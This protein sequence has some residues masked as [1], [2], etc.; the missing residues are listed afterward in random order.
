MIPEKILSL[1]VCPACKG[2]LDAG[3]GFSCRGCRATYEVVGDVPHLLDEKRK[4]G[5]QDLSRTFEFKSSLRNSRIFKALKYIFGAD[6]VPRDPLRQFNDLFLNK[7]GTGGLVLNMGSGST[8]LAEGVVNMDIE[9]LPNVDIVADGSRL[10]FPP[11]VFDAVI[12]EAVIEHVKDPGAFVSELKRV[13]KKGGVVF[14]VAPFVHHFHAYPNDFQRYSLEGLKV[15]FKDFD[16]MESGVYRGP[17]VALVN[18]LSEYA[19]SL[20]CSKPSLRLFLKSLFT[21]FLF[22]VKFLDL[23]LNKRADAFVLAHCVYY[24]GKKR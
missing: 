1:L 20:F 22:P 21:L 15:L 16:E 11:G 10:P 23:F 6:F 3:E 14:I 24:I 2:K 19:A 17:S 5:K 13:L 9:H 12:S 7:A 8:R 4:E 18:F